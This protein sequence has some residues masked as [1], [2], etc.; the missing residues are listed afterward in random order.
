MN[1][2]QN[3]MPL[4]FVILAALLSWCSISTIAQDTSGQMMTGP[5]MMNKNVELDKGIGY[6]AYDE[7][8]K[9]YRIYQLNV[10]YFKS[11]CFGSKC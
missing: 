10:D 3:L 8:R 9:Y 6:D 5:S 11:N 1:R 7:G 4:S 2:I